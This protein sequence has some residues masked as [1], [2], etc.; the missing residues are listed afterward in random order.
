MTATLLTP[1]E[2]SLLADQLPG[3]TVLGSKL[4]RQW[5][6]KNFVDAFGFM[7][8]VALLA[9]SMHHHPD[10]SNVY[11]R[12]TIELTTH[13]LGGL[14]DQDVQLAQAINLLQPN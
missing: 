2:I 8:R 4:Q 14:S 6:F 10:W 3:W 11:S 5:K 12:V 13:D 9:E 1:E 7:S